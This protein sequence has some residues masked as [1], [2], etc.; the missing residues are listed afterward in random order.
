MEVAKRVRIEKNGAEGRK[1]DPAV[2]KL[3]ATEYILGGERQGVRY[4]PR[5]LCLHNITVAE[6]AGFLCRAA[7]FRT[8]LTLIPVVETSVS[9]TVELKPETVTSN[10][11]SSSSSNSTES[12]MV[13]GSLP[14]ATALIGEVLSDLL[15]VG[16]CQHFVIV[17]EIL[18]TVS[19]PFLDKCIQG[20][21]LNSRR[22]EAYVSYVELLRRFQ[23]YSRANEII[24]Q[25]DNNAMLNQYGVMMHIS[26]SNCGRELPDG[27]NMPWCQKCCRSVGSCVICNE[28]VRGL[29]RWCAICSHGGHTDCTRKWFIDSNYATCPSGC[30]HECNALN[31]CA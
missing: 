7:L 11:N 8:I 4:T 5:E 23:Q 26:C 29:F 18:K 21:V 10:S 28:P 30:G 9:N 16:D 2:I 19:K 27:I 14:F 15:E 31:K 25:S 17:C 20:T 1:F 13:D 22:L 12:E 3:L 6:N 24:R